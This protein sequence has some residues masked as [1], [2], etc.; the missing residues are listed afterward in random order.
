MRKLSITLFNAVRLDLHFE[1]DERGVALVRKAFPHFLDRPDDPHASIFDEPAP[2]ATCITPHFTANGGVFRR[3]LATIRP[4]TIGEGMARF[5]ATIVQSYVDALEPA[6]LGALDREGWTVHVPHWPVL[7]RWIRLALR[8]PQA[9]RIDEDV[10]AAVALH[11][12]RHAASPG[13]LEGVTGDR[14]L[15]LLALRLEPDE[16][17]IRALVHFP[18]GHGVQ[19]GTGAARIVRP[20]GWYT[21]PLNWIEQDALR[22]VLPVER[23]ERALVQLDKCLERYPRRS[24]HG[25]ARTSDLPGF[26]M[27]IAGYYMGEILDL[28]FANQRT[29]KPMRSRN[30]PAP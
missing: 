26:L 27:R 19:E 4:A 30:P 8:T 16:P 11:V 3:R 17:E 24:G 1:H 13:A 18:H 23:V 25:N 14:W 9:L 28:A 10:V 22:D 15:R 2:G 21:H 7:E 5:H 20:P 6:D 29:A 12:L